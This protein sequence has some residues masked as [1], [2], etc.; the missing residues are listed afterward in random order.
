MI[1]EFSALRN[2]IS[3]PS[4]GLRPNSFANWAAVRVTIALDFFIEQLPQSLSSE[5][6]LMFRRRLTFFHESMHH[7]DP[8]RRPSV[9][10]RPV[11]AIS[12]ANSQLRYS[13]RHRWHCP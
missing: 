13:D 3:A 2:S 8:A 6:Q 1:F 7:Q 12:P 5:L 9:I 4:A 10:K 11:N